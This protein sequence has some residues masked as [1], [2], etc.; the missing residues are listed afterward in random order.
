[1]LSV[2]LILL[3]SDVGNISI[4]G[5]IVTGLIEVEIYWV[6]NEVVSSSDGQ[7]SKCLSTIDVIGVTYI[8]S[9]LWCSYELFLVERKFES[10]GR[11]GVYIR[12]VGHV[13]NLGTGVDSYAGIVSDESIGRA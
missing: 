9:D 5:K 1:M 8:A 10:L 6:D 11:I 3:H 4:T 13:I 7:T 12:W 2:H